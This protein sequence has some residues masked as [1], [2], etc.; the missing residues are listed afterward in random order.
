MGANGKARMLSNFTWD[1]TVER[2]NQI[3]VKDE[4]PAKPLIDRSPQDG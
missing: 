2:L 4:D 1:H 3:L